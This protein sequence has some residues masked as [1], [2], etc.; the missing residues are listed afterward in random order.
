MSFLGSMLSSGQGSGFQGTQAP[1]TSVTPATDQANAQNQS[2]I[3]QQQNFVNATQGQNGLANQNQVFQQQQALQN[4][5]QGVANG[6]GPNPAQAMLAQSTGANVANQAA[7]MAGQRG[8]GANVGLMARENAQQGAATQQQAAGQAATLQANQSLG[9][10]GQIGQQQNNMANLANTQ[11]ANQAGAIQGLQ[12][13]TAGNLGAQ[14]GYQQG[15]NNAAVQSQG[16]VNSANSAMA[17]QNAG[18]QQGILG[19]LT[20]AIGAAAPLALGA[21]TGGAS[22]AAP[23][24]LGSGSAL[25]VGG[26]SSLASIGSGLSAGLAHGGAVQGQNSF[27]MPDSSLGMA[28]GGQVEMPKSRVGMAM[29][30]SNAKGHLASVKQLMAEG[31]RASG[32][33]VVLSPGEK[34]LP[35]SKIMSKDPLKAAKTVPGKAKV[36]GDSYANDTYETKE[37]AGSIVFPRSVT[38]AKDRDSA[39]RKFVT[40]VLAKSRMKK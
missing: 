8:A 31:G 10:L 17:Q 13:A 11:V 2:A 4:Q 25:G 5:L 30:E 40:A 3:N 1:I 32:V 19:G 14:Y 33:D 12:G 9:A 37:K 36:P 21:L 28:T 39:A 35:P 6:T 20:G 7:L 26:G 18:A 24:L 34:V 27:T 38:Q 15:L 29:H 16:S 22:L 23:A